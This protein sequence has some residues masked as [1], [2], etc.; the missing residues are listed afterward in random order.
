MGYCGQPCEVDEDCI[1]NPPVMEQTCLAMMQC[2]EVNWCPNTLE[3]KAY[4][5]LDIHQVDMIQIHLLSTIQFPQIGSDNF[6]DMRI[7]T[8][9]D[10]LKMGKVDLDKV[11]KEGAVIRVEI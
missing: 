9:G 2:K 10:I 5:T 7:Y 11:K 3:K 4:S 8:V 1:S 6:S